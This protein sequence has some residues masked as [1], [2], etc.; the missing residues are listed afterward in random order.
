MQLS[1]REFHDLVRRAYDELPGEIMAS[2]ENVAILVED[3]PT[4]E[5]LQDA[6]IER[7]DQLF[8]L[9]KGVPL[10]ER[11]EFVP[12]LPD[13]ITLFKRPIELVCVNWEDVVREVRTTLLHEVGHYMGFGEE[14]LEEM[15]YG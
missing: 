3:W 15:G 11:G 9:Y 10:P 7:R 14:D 5:D 2:I 4:W 1:H 13:S 6:G 12:M 8:G